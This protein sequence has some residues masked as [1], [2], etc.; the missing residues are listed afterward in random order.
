VNIELDP[1]QGKISAVCMDLIPL[2]PDAIFYMSIR[3]LTII[4]I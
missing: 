3:G 4:G 1:S 2:N